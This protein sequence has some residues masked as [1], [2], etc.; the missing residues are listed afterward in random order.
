MAADKVINKKL[1]RVKHLR[2]FKYVIGI[3]WIAFIIYAIISGPGLGEVNFFYNTESIVSTD[4]AAGLI[5]YYF[6]AGM[7]LIL[8][9]L[10]GK[11]GMCHYLCPMALINI[12]GT[13]ASR[14]L[15]IP[16]LHLEARKDKCTGCGQCA[17][18]CPMS[19]DTMEMV[20]KGAVENTECIHCGEC[21]AACRFGAVYRTFGCRNRNALGADNHEGMESA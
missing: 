20:Q 14:I 17:K 19:L 12:A 9:L 15:N 2:I 3:V 5:R 11:R 1:A 7:L 16:S 18:A 6:I 10:L 8:S 4:S 21:G 13:K